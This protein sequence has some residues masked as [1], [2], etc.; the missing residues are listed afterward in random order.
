MCKVGDII[1][2]DK[3]KHGTNCKVMVV[4]VALNATNTTTVLLTKLLVYDI[5]TS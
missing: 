5:I 3:Y 2:I 1:L 4:E